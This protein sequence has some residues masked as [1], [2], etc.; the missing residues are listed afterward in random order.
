MGKQEGT[1]E[2]APHAWSLPGGAWFLLQIDDAEKLALLPKLKACGF[3]LTE[4]TVKRT[5]YFKVC[6]FA[7]MLF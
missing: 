3:K 2:R 4:E 7:A 5:D 1:T 6:T